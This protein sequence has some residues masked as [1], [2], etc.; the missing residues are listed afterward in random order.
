MLEKHALHNNNDHLQIQQ[1]N[2]CKMTT[3]NTFL[4]VYMY[5]TYLTFHL[6]VITASI[7]LSAITLQQFK[8]HKLLKQIN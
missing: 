6:Y 2:D 7:P 1:R 3:I 4:N 5:F 8:R